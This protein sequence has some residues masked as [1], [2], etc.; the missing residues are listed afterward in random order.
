ML[1]LEELVYMVVSR[2]MRGQVQGSI[3]FAQII[4]T[5]SLGKLVSFHK[6][7]HE[8][9]LVKILFGLGHLNFCYYDL[10]RNMSTGP[11]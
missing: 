5:N 7:G 2:L 11:R 3:S 6:E 4:L 9:A 10:F 8:R 1:K